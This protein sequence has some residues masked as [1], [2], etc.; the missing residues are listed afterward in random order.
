MKVNTGDIN[1]NK[2]IYVG[3][4][5]I[6]YPILVKVFGEPKNVREKTSCI[7]DIEFDD[8]T[9]ASIY[10]WKP[11]KD[12]TPETTTL[13]NI[14]GFNRKAKELVINEINKSVEIK[15]YHSM[16]FV[17]SSYS[18]KI[19][20]KRYSFG[21]VNEDEAKKLAIKKLKNLEIEYDESDIDFKWDGRL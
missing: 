10:D 5:L 15:F 13:W 21:F 7:W 9:V 19:D 3:E 16:G 6:S 12:A 18:M 14:G 1:V 4:I 17:G 2:T 11:S 8:G 20:D